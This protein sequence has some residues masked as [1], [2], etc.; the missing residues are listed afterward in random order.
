[1]AVALA[2]GVRLTLEA[3][4][5]SGLPTYV[6]LYPALIAVALLTGIGATLL[7]Y[8]VAVS[9][10]VYWIIPPVGQFAIASPVDWV[11]L[12]IFTLT[13]LCLSVFAELYRRNRDRVATLDHERAA[14]ESQARL[15]SFAAATFEGIVESQEGR[16]LD[17]NEQ[18]AR[19]VGYSL[20]ELKGKK[21][22]DLIAPEDLARVMA[23]IELRQESVSEH[24]ILRKDGSRMMVETRGRPV[25]SGGSARYTAIRDITERKRTDER[26]RLQARMLDSVGQ[27]VIAI[28]MEQK[29]LF[30]NKTASA[31]FGWTSE[32]VLG[33]NLQEILPPQ[34]N[35]ASPM[36]IMATLARGES[37]SGEVVVLARDKRRIPLFTTNAALCDENGRTIAI[38][39]VGTDISKRKE[40]EAIIQRQIDELTAFNKVSVGRELRMV[41]LKQEINRL[42]AENGQP[43]RYSVDFLADNYLLDNTHHGA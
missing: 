21:L 41:E 1:M 16:V 35:A 29:I 14:R 37:W 22:A 11:G 19:M 24:A 31:L 40:D 3:R 32:E 33:K 26:V 8:L 12:A 43:P 30:W 18:F 20:A 5:G 17:C 4:F 28:D 25:G 10:T 38:I 13:N 36:E 9:V 27:A 34:S 23:K 6:T 42:C 2:M 39:G 15:D 7:A